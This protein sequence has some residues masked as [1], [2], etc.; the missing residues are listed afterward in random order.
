[1][2]TIALD[3]S[4]AAALR[5]AA[6]ERGWTPESLAVDCLR[7]HLEIAVRHRVLLERMEMVDAALL[8]MAEGIAGLALPGD[9]IDLSKVCR[10]RP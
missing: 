6:V 7:Q 10:Y 2:L 1:M 9:G 8:E 3:A 4:L 5:Q